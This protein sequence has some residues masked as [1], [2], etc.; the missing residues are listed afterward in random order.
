MLLIRM[1]QV[2][3]LSAIAEDNFI[4]RMMEHLE[5]TFPDVTDPLTRRELRAR[6]EATL[7]CA[8]SYG[9]DNEADDCRFLSLAGA[10]GWEFD[11][12]PANEWMRPMLA[13]SD[14]DGGLAA[15]LQACLRRLETDEQDV[16]S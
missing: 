13:P 10:Y 5:E 7:A 1:S 6:V 11:S 15:L 2:A 9:I 4:E 16:A 14:G 3:A 8:R 12:A